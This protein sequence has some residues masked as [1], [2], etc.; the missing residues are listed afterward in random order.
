MEDILAEFDIID[1][2]GGLPRDGHRTE[3][4]CDLCGYEPQSKNRLRAKQV[5]IV[6][7]TFSYWGFVICLYRQVEFLRKMTRPASGDQIMRN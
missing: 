7:V 4:S 6:S 2:A 3:F 1:P 5:G